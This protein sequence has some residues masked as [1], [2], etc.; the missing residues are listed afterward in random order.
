MGEFGIA[1][2]MVAGLLGIDGV[3]G[4]PWER[5]KTKQKLRFIFHIFGSPLVLI[6][7]HLYS[8][9]QSQSPAEFKMGVCLSL[10]R[11]KVLGE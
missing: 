6:S 2:S 5:E 3:G 8:L 9:R 11:D 4:I 10:G 7:Y 1:P